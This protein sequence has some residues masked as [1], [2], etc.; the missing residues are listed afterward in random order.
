MIGKL[1]LGLAS[2]AL[3]VACVPPGPA[4]IL[5]GTDIALTRD[6]VLRGVKGGMNID[7]VIARQ[8][9]VFTCTPG[10]DAATRAKAALAWITQTQGQVGDQ[11]IGASIANSGEMARV[12]PT[13]DANQGCQVTRLTS[14]LVTNDRVKVLKFVAEH[15]LMPELIAEMK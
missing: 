8:S 12:N 9:Y 7:P 11:N 6:V 13:I 14:A 4:P 2:L 15:G 3:L 1:S 5:G 10:P